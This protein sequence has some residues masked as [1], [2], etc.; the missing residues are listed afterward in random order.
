[1]STKFAPSENDNE[2][3]PLSLEP[4]EDATANEKQLS[5]PNNEEESSSSSDSQS[6][7][8][9]I[10]VPP[11]G[12]WGWVVVFGSFMCNLIVDG[13]IFSFG[14]FLEDMAKDLGE[15][16]ASTALVGS[17]LTGFYLMVGPFTSAIANRYGFQLVAVIGCFLGAIGF[18]AS[19]FVHSVS[20]LCFTYGII[21]GKLKPSDLWTRILTIFFPIGIGLGFIYVPAVVTVGFYFEKWRALATGI[22]V[23]GSG[24]GTFIFAPL[25]AE[26]LRS[27][28]WRASLL[29]LAGIILTCGIFG[30][31]FR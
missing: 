23:C 20:L 22:G 31:T 28:Q 1:M 12:G 2:Y 24:I 7:S 21:G 27:L 14:L 13:I 11:D 25:C 29:V 5:K 16:T 3:Q 15:T 19:Y 8:D 18:A 6:D 17:L 26:L 30:L 10:I 9:D 4:P